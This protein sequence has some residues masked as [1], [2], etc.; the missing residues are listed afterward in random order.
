MKALLKMSVLALVM[1]VTAGCASNGGS[2][3]GASDK[4]VIDGIVNDMMAALMAQDIDAMMAP[5]SE[6]FESDQGGDLEATREFLNTAKEGGV[7]DGMEI[8]TS[9]METTIEGDKASVGPV[10]I[11]ASFGTMT[12]EFDLEKR[13]GKWLVVYMAQY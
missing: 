1:V 4:D 2:G 3:G 5:Y 10:D 11:E 7:L 13:G 6:D 8:D 9:A 12:L